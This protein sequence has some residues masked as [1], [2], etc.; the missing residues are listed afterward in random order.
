[1]FADLLKAAFPMQIMIRRNLHLSPWQAQISL[2]LGQI[3]LKLFLK[4]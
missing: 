3:T 2:K 4:H 1:M